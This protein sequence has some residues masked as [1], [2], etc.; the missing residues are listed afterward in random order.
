M[1][2][3]VERLKARVD[4]R[5]KAAATRYVELLTRE[6]LSKVEDDELEGLLNELGKSVD[7]L[8]GD[9]KLIQQA[10]GDETLAAGLSDAKT[11]CDATAREYAQLVDV[12]A[13]ARRL[14]LEKEIEG[15][16][17]KL[18][19]AAGQAKAAWESA[20]AAA[21]RIRS[22]TVWREALGRGCSVEVICNERYETVKAR[23]V[24]EARE[25]REHERI[26]REAAETADIENPDKHLRRLTNV[27]A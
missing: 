16:D 20:K 26:A 11:A 27:P 2:D 14:A 9:A 4:E 13:P 10:P 8:P 7:D 12:Q 1:M 19:R 22:F 25:L 15:E 23:G 18:R 24:A 3:T 21:Q 5:R 6:K 17:T